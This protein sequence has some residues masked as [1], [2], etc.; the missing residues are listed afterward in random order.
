MTCNS[1]RTWA[2][3]FA[4]LAMSCLAPVA[5]AQQAG[6]GAL[7]G[8]GGSGGGGGG[9]GGSISGSGNSLFGSGGAG[10]SGGAGGTSQGGAGYTGGQGGGQ[11]GFSG[12]T[13]GTTGTRAGAGGSTVTIPSN[14]NLFRGTYANPMSYGISGT[15]GT[16]GKATFGQPLFA[17]ATTATTKGKTTART[18]TNTSNVTGFN[19]FGQYR[20]PPYTT[21]LGEDVGLVAK[22]APALQASLHDAIQ[23]SSFLKSKTSIGVSV[24]EGRVMLRGQVAS[25]RERRL[26]ESI[27]RLTPGVRDVGNELTISAS[28]AK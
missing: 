22:A 28:N 1:Q 6:G 25:E 10:F 9:G 12:V 19:T 11:G 8:A 17:P 15:T 24:E 3:L 5:R 18:T 16:A 4:C 14:S 27:V 7:G 23:R 21:T 13:T 2:T 26:A 20:D